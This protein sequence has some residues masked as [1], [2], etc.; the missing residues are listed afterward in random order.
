MSS[1]NNPLLIDSHIHL[2]DERFSDQQAQLLTMARANNIAAFVVPAVCQRFWPRLKALCDAH[3]DLHA[4]YGL[5]PRF[6]HEHSDE[7]LQQLPLW[8]GKESPVAIGEC[9][10]DYAY[11]GADKSAQQHLFGAQ[12]ALAREFNLPIVIHAVRAV[13]DVIRMIRASGHRRGMVHSFNGSQQ[14]A[15]KLIDLGYKLSFGG[16]VT[17]PKAKKLQELVASLPLEAVLLETDAPDQ[18][19]VPYQGAQNQ[20]HYLIDVWQCISTI[21]NESATAIAEAT[22]HNARQL[23][24]LSEAA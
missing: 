14:Q 2:D 5:H 10:L 21:R 11:A 15:H 24:N 22:S 9:G 19:P 17:Y 3:N 7:H 23:F 12:L 6:F 16:A 4:C 13:E 18:P 1:R 20:P 8:L